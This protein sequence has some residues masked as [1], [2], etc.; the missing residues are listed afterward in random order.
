MDFT[1]AIERRLEVREYGDA[2]V[3]DDIKHAVVDAARLAPSS[4]NRQD[5]HFLLIDDALDDLAA[6]S[7]TGTWVADAAFAVVVLT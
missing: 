4:R 1:E 7:P 2:P 3:S 6:M 5:W